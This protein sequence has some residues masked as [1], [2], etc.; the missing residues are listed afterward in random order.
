[1]STEFRALIEALGRA[2]VDFVLIGGVA[3]VAHGHLRATLD[4]DICYA[5]TAENLERLAA[6]L[7]PFHPT[8]RG[9]PGDLPFRLD[10][11][12][13]RSGLNFTLSTDVGDVDLFGEVTGV[14]S[15]AEVA[16]GA[17]DLELYAHSV[18]V[19][20]LEV[21]ERAKRAG[22]RAKD[23]LDLEAIREIRQRQRR[24]Q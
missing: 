8:L 21:L 16:R 20:S 6:A 22:G 11:R 23:L 24:R 14:G 10:A 17:V 2:Q 4:L 18:R 9:A 12:T 3:V 13:L 5:R 1:V 7:A 15:Y 19:A